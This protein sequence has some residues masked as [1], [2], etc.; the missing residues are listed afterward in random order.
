MNPYP[1]IARRISGAQWEA[2][3]RD[4]DMVIFTSAPLAVSPFYSPATT[5]RSVRRG[6]V[7]TIDRHRGPGRSGVRLPIRGPNPQSFQQ[8]RR[9]RTDGHGLSPKFQDR[10]LRS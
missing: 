1:T 4:V 9:A 7:R 3:L 2:D 10:Y 8:W 5:S 6:Q